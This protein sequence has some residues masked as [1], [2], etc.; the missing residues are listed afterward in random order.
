MGKFTFAGHSLSLVLLAFPIQIIYCRA[1]QKLRR[2]EMEPAILTEKIKA[3]ASKR[4]FLVQ[5][6]AQPNL[7]TLRLDVTQ[8]LEEL[9]ELLDEFRLTFPAETSEI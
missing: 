1:R 8:A 4:E 9:D 3:I 7:G 5:I 6:L 2:R